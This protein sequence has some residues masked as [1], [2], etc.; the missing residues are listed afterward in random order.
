MDDLEYISSFMCE[1]L[2]HLGYAPT[3]TKDGQEAVV[4]FRRAEDAGE[5]FRACILD[6][7]IPEGMGGIETAAAIQ[8]IR[9]DVV[10][11]ASSGYSESP[12]LLEPKGHGFSASLVKP[13]RVEDLADILEHAL[14][15]PAADS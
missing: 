10:L 2:E 13:F 4:E 5:P 9:S 11:V 1:M 6:L 7:T 15:L 14:A 12:V 8:R 3:A